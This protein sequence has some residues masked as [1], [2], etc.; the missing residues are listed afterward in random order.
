[1]D[2]MESIEQKGEVEFH[3]VTNMNCEHEGEALNLD[4]LR[5]SNPSS[6]SLMVIKVTQ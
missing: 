4:E 6:D 1:M 2:K 5:G 3:F